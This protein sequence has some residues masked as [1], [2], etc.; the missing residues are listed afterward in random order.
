MLR[1]TSLC[2]S[3]SAALCCLVSTLSAGQPIENVLPATVKAF[4]ATPSLPELRQKFNET[5]IGDMIKD[6]AM[7][8]FV[9]DLKRQVKE[10][11]AKTGAKLGVTLEDLEGIAGELSL[12]ALQ[13]GDKTTHAMVLV[14]D[15]KDGA[16]E[17]KA[18]L[19][20]I[21]R[22][23]TAL[24][25][26]KTARNSAGAAMSVYTFPHKQDQAFVERVVVFT[27]KDRLVATDNV[28]VADDIAI[29]LQTPK[30]DNLASLPAYKFIQE[31]FATETSAAGP[32]LRWYVDPFGYAEVAR[33]AVERKRRGT[34][35][36]KIL[37]SQGFSAVKAL[38]GN[39][40]LATG[41]EELLHR[42]FVYAP[43]VARKPGSKSTEK[44]NLAARMLD[45]PNNEQLQPQAW[46][47]DHVAGYLTF[48][49][50]MQK[51]FNVVGSLVDAI[52]GEQGVFDE[53][54]LSLK[55]DPN[56]PK[57]DVREGLAAKLKDRATFMTDYHLPI[58]TDSERWL[59]AVEISDDAVVAD[60]VKKA[61]E[62]DPTAKRR[63]AEGHV[64]WE[65]IRDNSEIEAP[66]LTV[67]GAGF[68]ATEAAPVETESARLPNSAITVWHGHLVVAS[69]VDA[70]VDLMKKGA[71]PS[72]GLAEA[73]DFNQVQTALQ[74]LGAGSDAFRQFS[75]S[76]ETLRPTYELLQQGK[77]PE[78]ETLLAKALNAVLS[79][80]GETRQQ[81]ID[82]SKL[83][84]FD[85]VR[86][87]LGPTGLYVRTEDAGWSIVG[88]VL[89]KAQ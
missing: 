49:W 72:A 17:A 33:A 77:M 26:V 42:T 59:V 18:L 1:R 60:T 6:P 80:E 62:H 4:V 27:L 88:C 50:K 47:P 25:T 83:P 61:F 40:N 12:A 76:D 29:R 43:A 44:Y 32:Q 57:V 35:M 24:G 69:H 67:E 20:K 45:F 7:Q 53:V 37:Q 15:I 79:K 23:Q 14:A 89:K 68:V 46:V 11:L 41:D 10:K 21:D 5:Q 74:R 9:D 78:A 58:R 51:A 82:G 39:V 85:S 22:N 54:L 87:Y 19:A 65:I 31:R 63:I 28:A 16:D 71:N 3:W 8:P 70:V 2:L 36:L 86:K 48:N 13:P 75:R 64:I 56:G 73:A 55:T 34:D 84:P 30:A 38:G 81:Q 52:A 66:T